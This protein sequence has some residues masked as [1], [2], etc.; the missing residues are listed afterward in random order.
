MLIISGRNVGFLP[1]RALGAEGQRTARS[2][3]PAIRDGA[4]ASLK[5]RSYGRACL[6]ISHRLIQK[7]QYTVHTN[8]YVDL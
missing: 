8:A 3:R 1:F 5:I 4:A 2:E 6:T 7:V